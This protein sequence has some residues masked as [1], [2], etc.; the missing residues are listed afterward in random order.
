MPEVTAS[1]G[2][3]GDPTLEEHVF[4][5]AR[6]RV[7]GRRYGRNKY[8]LRPDQPCTCQDSPYRDRSEVPDV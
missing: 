6:L 3:A 1:Y 5:C 2:A 8:E 7:I 4:G